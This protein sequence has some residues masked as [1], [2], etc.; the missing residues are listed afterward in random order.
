VNCFVGKTPTLRVKDVNN[1]QAEIHLIGSS[2]TAA[3]I[4]ALGTDA[5][6]FDRDFKVKGVTAGQT[7]DFSITVRGKDVVNQTNGP[8]TEDSKN[9]LR[10]VVT[11]DPAKAELEFSKAWKPFSLSLG[12]SFKTSIGLAATEI[13]SSVA[14]MRQGE[15]D[16]WSFAN[17][18]YTAGHQA[19]VRNQ[20]AISTALGG[21]KSWGEDR[22]AS[23]GFNEECEPRGFGAGSGG[24][25]DTAL[26]ASY[27]G[28]FGGLQSIDKLML[29]A[30][31]TL[32]KENANGHQNARLTW[33][34]GYF[35]IPT[36][37]PPSGNPDP[38]TK[39]RNELQ[40]QLFGGLSFQ[41]GMNVQACF[42]AGGR[43]DP[44]F[45]V[46]NVTVTPS[47]GAPITKP[48]DVGSNDTWS[49]RFDGLKVGLTY[50][51][52]VEYPDES[53]T[54]SCGLTMPW[55]EAIP[56]FQPFKK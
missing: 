56:G 38:G 29:G 12:L 37:L 22:L 45:G 47:V 53:R 19:L 46:P 3:T 32:D 20:D 35:Q 27:L 7:A 24:G 33:Q 21:Y 28:G 43:Y 36:W 10:V 30:R 48:A 15:L 9:I 55:L 41:D 49:T 39:S 40:I 44:A 51:M 17:N 34:P 11:D 13:K 42:W 8:C 50:R 25:W 6:T 16:V 18:L 1:C 52:D 14:D 31:K 4:T 26:R 2:G 5:L 54:E 23:G